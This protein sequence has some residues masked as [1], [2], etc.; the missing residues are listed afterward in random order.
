MVDITKSMVD[1]LIRYGRH[2]KM[3]CRR[4]KIIVDILKSMVDKL[5]IIEDKLQKHGRH[6]YSML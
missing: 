2:T 1:I 3:Y 4:T 6:W 5:K